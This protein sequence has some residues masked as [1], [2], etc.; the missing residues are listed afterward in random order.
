M[1]YVL[2]IQC[3][4]NTMSFDITGHTPTRY[5]YV[6]TNTNLTVGYTVCNNSVLPFT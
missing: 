4:A 5:R 6:D 2:S 3:L 1:T